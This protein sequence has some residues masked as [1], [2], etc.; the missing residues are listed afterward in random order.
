M[1]EETVFD[2]SLDGKENCLDC[3]DGNE[4][5]VKE[6]QILKDVASREDPLKLKIRLFVFLLLITKK[7]NHYIKVEEEEAVLADNFKGEEVLVITNC[8]ME[9]LMD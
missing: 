3:E 1:K 8:R 7:V 9:H 2:H 5:N 6:K 4:I